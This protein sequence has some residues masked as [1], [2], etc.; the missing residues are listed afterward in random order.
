MTA[1][2]STS[3][4]EPAALLRRRPALIDT[5]GNGSA[6]GFVSKID[7]TQSG[8]NSLVYSTYLGGSDFDYVIGIDVDD[9]GVA[10]LTGF[11]NQRSRRHRMATTRS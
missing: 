3:A 2:T 8:A 10:Y 6:D 7:P 11:A 5:T 1:A 4:D 9:S